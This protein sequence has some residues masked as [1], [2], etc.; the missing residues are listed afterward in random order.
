MGNLH[1]VIAFASSAE[2]FNCSRW[3]YEPES[4]NLL[5]PG[6]DETCAV[7]TERGGRLA[8]WRRPHQIRFSCNLNDQN[9]L[10]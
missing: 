3:N 5:S 8:G 2:Q 7:K 4:S 6:P 9:L 1:L 10:L